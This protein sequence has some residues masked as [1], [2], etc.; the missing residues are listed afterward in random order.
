MARNVVEVEV[1]LPK[2]LRQYRLWRE[3]ARV[4]V[5]RTGHRLE[6]GGV[7]VVGEGPLQLVVEPSPAGDVLE[8]S[9][10][11]RG[12]LVAVLIDP[13]ERRLAATER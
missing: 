7:D 2:G 12:A 11:R 6:G 10:Y 5:Q 4:I 1:T 13:L 3:G 9:V 8:L